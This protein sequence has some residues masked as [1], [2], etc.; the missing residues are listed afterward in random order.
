MTHLTTALALNAAG[1]AAA[2]GLVWA[3]L[4]PSNGLW[5]RVY[6]R[7]PMGAGAAARYALTFDD[8][9]TRG[10][11]D[12]ILDI[13]RE[14]KVRAAFFVVGANVRRCPDLLARMR[15]EGHLVANHT[16]DHDHYSVF[17]G[18]RY[19]DRQLAE[20]DRLIAE[21]AG[22][23]PAMFRPPMGFKTYY[24]MSAARRRGQAVITWSRRAVDGIVT[25]RQRIL[26]RLVPRAAAGDVLLLHDGIEPHSRRRDAAATVAAVRPLIVQLRDR[27]LEP[28][29]LDEFL[30]LRAYLP[31]PAPL[32]PA[33]APTASS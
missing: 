17:R 12:E 3:S 15:D 18:R 19:W 28:A 22:L 25:T 4:T 27:G 8:G 29:P 1:A 21:A 7:G 14:L 30:G 32:P 20:T 31:L 33:D 16:L 23:R 5:G 9:P 26:D 10:S 6:S 11:T 13:L 2:G 24:S